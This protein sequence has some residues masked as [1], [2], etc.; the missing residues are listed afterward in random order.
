ME[1][2]KEIFVSYSGSK[3]ALEDLKA[4]LKYYDLD[5]FIAPKD[6]PSGNLPE[7]YINDRIKTCDC[8]LAIATESAADSGRC[9]QEVGMAIDNKKNIIAIAVGQTDEIRNEVIKSFGFLS[10]RQQIMNCET[11]EDIEFMIFTDRIFRGMLSDN[12]RNINDGYY[13]YIQQDRRKP[14]PENSIVLSVDDWNDN[15][16]KTSFEMSKEGTN[17][18]IAK[19]TFKTHPTHT[20]VSNYLLN[21]FPALGH[22]MFSRVR[23]FKDIKNVKIEKEEKYR[24]RQKLNDINLEINRENREG[25]ILDNHP[26]LTDSLHRTKEPWFFTTREFDDDVKTIHLE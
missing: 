15:E 26:Q 9:Q 25:L 23:F 17:I 18:G 5:L 20:H 8:L 10:D 21:Y 1:S 7:D 24:I 11:V 3:T 6:I 19:I 12:Y 2:K 22:Q 13:F 14:I 16:Y 4:K